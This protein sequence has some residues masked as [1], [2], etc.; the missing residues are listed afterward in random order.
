MLRTCIVVGLSLVTQVTFSGRKRRREGLKSVF[1]QLSFPPF[2]AE[3]E[4]H[5]K[6][7]VLFPPKE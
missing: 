7:L 4:H 5:Q 6:K 2:F 3:R 1:E